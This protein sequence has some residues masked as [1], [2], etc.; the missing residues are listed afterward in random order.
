MERHGVSEIVNDGR[1]SITGAFWSPSGDGS[2]RVSLPARLVE[3]DLRPAS[4]STLVGTAA[5]SGRST[6]VTLRRAECGSE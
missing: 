2:I 5:I 4:T 1:R 3:M 6:S